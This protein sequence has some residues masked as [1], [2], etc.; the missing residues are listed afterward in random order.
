MHLFLGYYPVSLQNLP[1]RMDEPIFTFDVKGFSVFG[2]IFSAAMV[3]LCILVSGKYL[4]F[5]NNFNFMFRQLFI[6]DV[7]VRHFCGFCWL[8]SHQRRRVCATTEVEDRLSIIG[9]YHFRRSIMLV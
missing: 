6:H 3:L 4:N 2:A 5:E 7:L 9:L 1:E 8:H